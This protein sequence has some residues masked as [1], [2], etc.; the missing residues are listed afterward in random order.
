MFAAFADI[1]S[2]ADNTDTTTAP[3]PERRAQPLLMGDLLTH[4]AGEPEFL[5]R[6][7]E[8]HDRIQND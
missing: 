6:W 7:R 1:W 3:K 8:D 5:I 2:F 4:R